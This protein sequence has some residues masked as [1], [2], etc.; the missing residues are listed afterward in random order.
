MKMVLIWNFSVSKMLEKLFILVWSDFT[1]VF[2]PDSL[3]IVDQISVEFDWILVEYRVL[4]NYLFYFGFS[5]E[6]N[7]FRIKFQ[8][9]LCSSSK[10]KVINCCNFILSTSIRSPQNSCFALFF[11]YYRDIIGN[12]K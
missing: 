2:V 9:Y 10:I 1:F 7:G 4:F 8:S 3:Q 5:T 11:C 12:N 6:L